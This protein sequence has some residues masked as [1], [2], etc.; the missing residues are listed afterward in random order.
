MFKRSISCR[1]I[2][3]DVIGVPEVSVLN[4]LCS[5][6]HILTLYSLF[7]LF[8]PMLAEKPDILVSTP[9]RLLAH[10]QADNVS[11]KESLEIL[12]IDEAD[13]VFSFGYQ[14]DLQALKGLVILTEFPSFMSPLLKFCCFCTVR[15]QEAIAP[16]LSLSFLC[17]F[18]PQDISGFLDVCHFE[19]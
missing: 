7:A 8:R 2:W 3:A 15:S 11:L 12:V 6:P 14:N 19:R 13:L 9:A 16:F 5:N 17:Q 4:S 18:L 1:Y 10:L